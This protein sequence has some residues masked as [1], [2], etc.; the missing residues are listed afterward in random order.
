MPAGAALVS[1]VG[2]SEFSHE[3]FFLGMDTRDKGQNDG[4]NKEQ[5]DRAAKNKCPADHGEEGAEITGVPL[6]VNGY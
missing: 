2:F 4:D 5:S 1:A 6:S 3:K